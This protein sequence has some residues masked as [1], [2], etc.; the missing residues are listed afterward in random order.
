M[1][2]LVS[3]YMSSEGRVEVEQQSAT[4]LESLGQHCLHLSTITSLSHTYR[5]TLSLFSFFCTLFWYVHEPRA[6]GDRVNGS[7]MGG[8]GWVVRSYR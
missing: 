8:G 1:G 5:H 3:P 4:S 2:G 6:A 7:G